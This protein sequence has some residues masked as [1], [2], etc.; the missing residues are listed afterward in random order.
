MLNSPHPKR[1]APPTLKILVTNDDGISSPGLWALAESLK[2]IGEV[3]VVAPDRQQSGVGSSV[4]LHHAVR[5]APTI[6]NRDG[7]KSYAVEGTPGDSVI[8]AT[9]KLVKDPIDLLVSGINTG[10]NMGN[11]VFVSGT[12]GA[13]FHGFFRGIPSMAVSVTALY[14]VHFEPAARVAYLLA[15]KARDGLFPPRALINVNVP[16]K[17]LSQLKGLRVTRL[18]D[19][20][21]TEVVDE[22]NDPRRLHYWINRSRPNW[23][24][25]PG[26]DIWA[27][28]ND[29][30]SITPLHNDVTAHSSLPNLTG[31]TDNI[32]HDLR[33]GSES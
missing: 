22:G 26:T 7:I 10:S 9:E 33:N 25:Q 12:V 24:S 16:N 28:E 23:T 3:V 19:G 11:D 31:L 18:A 15:L 13:A 1:G 17:P 20:S 5:M 27:A 21:Y 2:G 6:F 14:D 4:T 30:I 8:L 32:F 29:L